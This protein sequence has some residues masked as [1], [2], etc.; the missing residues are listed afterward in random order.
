MSWSL[1]HQKELVLCSDVKGYCQIL[2]HRQAVFIDQSTGN[3]RAFEDSARLHGWSVSAS[4]LRR[5]ANLASIGSLA[6]RRLTLTCLRLILL[7]LI[8]N[9]F[10]FRLESFEPLPKLRAASRMVFPLPDHLH[11]Q[12]KLFILQHLTC[13]I[14]G[15]RLLNSLILYNPNV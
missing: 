9:D 1:V 2:A 14:N 8:I 7:F 11:R 10:V 6:I 5:G 4:L 12:T 13:K 15:T 3:L